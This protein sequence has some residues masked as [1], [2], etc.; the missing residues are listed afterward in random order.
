MA[1]FRVPL[2]EA[3]QPQRAGSDGLQNGFGNLRQKAT[4]RWLAAGFNRRIR[5]TARTVVWEGDRAQ[6]RSLDPIKYFC[7]PGINPSRNVA[8][9]E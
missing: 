7:P 5:K 3:V 8:V 2:A 9:I 1:P 6:S 4:C